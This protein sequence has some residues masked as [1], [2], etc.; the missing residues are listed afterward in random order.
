MPSNKNANTRAEDFREYA[1][2]VQILCEL[3]DGGLLLDAEFDS[4]KRALMEE[5]KVQSDWSCRRTIGLTSGE[6]GKPK[7]LTER[8]RKDGR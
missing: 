6:S 7:E 1:Y 8:R 4:A 2:A 3:R 5:Y